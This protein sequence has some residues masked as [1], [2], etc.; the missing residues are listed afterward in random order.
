ML[1]L[2]SLQTFLFIPKYVHMHTI[3][4]FFTAKVSIFGTGAFLRQGVS[5]VGRMNSA[6]CSCSFED[7]PV[8]IKGDTMK[9]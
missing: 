7:G 1:L 2:K 4:I 5:W 6:L 9:R 8:A 3:F